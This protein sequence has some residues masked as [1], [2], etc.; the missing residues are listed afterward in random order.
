MNTLAGLRPAAVAATTS[1]SRARTRGCSPR[2]GI[3]AEDDRDALLAGLDA[4]EA[5]LRDGTFPFRDDDEDI[6]M[7][8][9]GG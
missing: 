2:S 7:A 3:I 9:S 5:E 1:P 8:S 6:H 4:V